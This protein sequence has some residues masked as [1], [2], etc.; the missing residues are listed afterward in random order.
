M[1]ELL[2]LL[3]V[4]GAATLAGAQAKPPAG[5]APPPFRRVPIEVKSADFVGAERLRGRGYT[6]SP[7][8]RND[9]WINTYAM[10]TD[11]GRFDVAG[12]DALLDRINE[13]A[14]LH[15]LEELARSSAM[16]DAAKGG[17]TAPAKGAIAVVESPVDTTTG[18]AK[19][20]GRW[21]ANVGRATTSDDP[22][23]ENV[24]SAFTS[25]DSTKRAYALGFGVD[26][27]TTF[28]PVQ[29]R[30]GEVARSSV[31]A[32][33]ATTVAMG[34]VTPEGAAGAAITGLGI[35]ADLNE[36]LADNPA[37]TIR[38]INEDKLREMGVPGHDAAALLRNFNYT[39][40]QHT[41]LVAALDRMG[42]ARGKEVFVSHATAAPSPQIA[43]F[44]TLRAQMMA[45]FVEKHGPA[46]IVG[47]A[48]RP[49]LR[50]RS[51]RIVGLMPFDH[52]AWTRDLA[53]ADHR[54][55]L[56]MGALPG[57][58]AKELW[59]EGRVGEAARG[60]LES[61]GWVVKER[62]RLTP[63]QSRG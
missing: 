50:T 27:W 56:E 49:W 58:A 48:G 39:P 6:V 34:M 30:L 53:S 23:Q 32:G 52:V 15:K 57:I 11:W 51:N 3:G 59:F 12:T 18:A 14:A 25:Y 5:G 2:L 36:M 46:D 7:T 17:V 19:G 55:S 45:R 24:A 1:R 44:M 60:F 20:M 10:Q 63:R 31:G 43:R 41:M 42:G 61:R 54:S 13:I 35:T 29:K 62:V 22:H 4:L 16:A 33:I 38:R 8:A 40:T 37:G 28:E 47:L 21:M 9:G 26:P